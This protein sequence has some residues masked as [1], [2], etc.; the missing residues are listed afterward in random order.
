MD[1][2]SGE[3]NLQMWDCDGATEDHI[4]FIVPTEGSGQ[5]RRA[6]DTSKCLDV[7]SGGTENGN[8]IM[9]WECVDGNQNQ[10]FTVP[11]SG[12]GNILWTLHPNKCLDVSGGGT[13]NGVNVQLWDCNKEEPNQQWKLP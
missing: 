9:I 4:R 10:Q 5:I 13:D 2:A 1:V 8:N 7:A 11:Y 12:T 6:S 3:T